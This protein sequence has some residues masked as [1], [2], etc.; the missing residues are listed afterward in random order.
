[1]DLL[2]A[3]TTAARTEVGPLKWA[4]LPPAWM[5]TLLVVASFIWIRSLYRRERGRSG[6]LQ[7]GLLTLIRTAVLILVLLVLSGPFRAET[8]T[9][10]ERSHLVVLIDSSHS[11]TVKDRYPE[12]EAKRL[13]DSAY[14][15]GNRPKSIEDVSRGE[16]VKRILAEPA[17]PEEVPRA[18]PE[19]RDR[20][21]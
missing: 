20:G 9:A 14:D 2:L 4:D 18:R 1:M 11:M 6:P 8:R 17:A 7:R 12:D 3:S 15:A 5:L 21:G 10:T 19:P 16:L 13:L